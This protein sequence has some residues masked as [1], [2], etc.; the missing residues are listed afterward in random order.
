MSGKTFLGAAL[1][2]VG[3]IAVPQ[4]AHATTEE[5]VQLTFANVINPISDAYI[6]LFSGTSSA[7]TFDGYAALQN[8][9]AGSSQQDIIFSPAGSSQTTPA[10]LPNTPDFYALAGVYSQ[11]SSLGT[12]T[13]LS[14]GVN[15]AT[16]ADIEGKSYA[17]VFP[18]PTIVTESDVVAFLQDPNPDLLSTSLQSYTNEFTDEVSP[19]VI[20]ITGTPGELVDFSNGTAGGQVDASVAT[21]GSAPTGPV[22]TAI[23]LPAAVWSALP[24]MGILVGA[25]VLRKN[26]LA[27]MK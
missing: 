14:V 6:A 3:L 8:I 2:I 24:L 7:V 9:N 4:W 12:T 10:S 11:S 19:A 5:E 25:K 23:P 22:T 13:G 20:P 26:S 18:D 27:E 1:A 15:V 17:D 21:V 16:S